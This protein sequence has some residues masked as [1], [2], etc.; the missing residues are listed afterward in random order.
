M[1]IKFEFT[2]PTKKAVVVL[3]LIGVMCGGMCGLSIYKQHQYNKEIDSLS[4]IA[5][6]RT[7]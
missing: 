7:E 3:T 4:N 2:K 5:L 1:Q 6:S